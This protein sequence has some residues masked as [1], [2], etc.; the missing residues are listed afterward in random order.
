MSIF[1]IFRKKERIDDEYIVFE[2][3][4]TVK[5]SLPSFERKLL[6]K[7][8]IL[9]VIGKRGS[10][11]TA[12]GMKFLELFHHKTHKQCYVLGYSD[13]KLPG[14]VK[15]VDDVEQAKINSTVLIDEGAL[16]FSARESMKDAN[17]AISRI[18]AI[19]RHKNLTLIFVSQNSAMI[20]VNVLRLV[21]TLILKEPSLLQARFE[22]KALRD[23]YG[24]I[25]FDNLK[26]KESHLFIY[27]DDFQG[28]VR[29][30]LPIFWSDAIS[31]SFKNK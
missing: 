11:K 18:M 23:I 21:D 22:R 19:A 2:E 10:G 1:D 28:M 13:V 8:L 30:D 4:K 26:D 9:L 29:F 12:A 5:G 3:I 20:D 7:S 15:K 14:W 6:K 31:T 27:D 25:T 17:K 24:E 16:S